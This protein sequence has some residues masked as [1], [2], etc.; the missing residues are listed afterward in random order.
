MQGTLR[1]CRIEENIV[2]SPQQI[3]KSGFLC[4]IPD[5]PDYFNADQLK[6]YDEVC[7]FLISGNDFRPID[8]FNVILFCHEMGVLLEYGRKMNTQRFEYLTLPT[9]EKRSVVRAQHRIYNDCLQNT[10]KLS[11][12]L[13]MSPQLRNRMFGGMIKENPN[14]KYFT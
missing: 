9:G 11:A 4:T 5:P 6:I 7:K 10:V 12:E 2:I 3:E 1:P 14:D 13:G 8:L